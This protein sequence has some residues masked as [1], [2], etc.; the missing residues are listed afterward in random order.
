[1]SE[2]VTGEAVALELRLAKLPSR[3]LAAFIDLMLQLMLLYLVEILGLVVL[4]GADEGLA[5]ALII[6]MIVAIFVGYPVTMETL[7]RGRT[8]GK[9]VMGIRVVREDGGPIGF[10]QALVRGLFAG[11]LEKPGLLFAGLTAVI[12]IL[13]MLISTK[14]KRVG[15]LAAGTVVLQERVPATKIAYYAQMPPPLAGWAATLDITGVDDSLAL[16]V[17]QFLS[18]LAQLDDSARAELGER[19]S[20]AVAAVTTPPPPPGTPG[21]A[22][23]SAVLAE[24]RRREEQRL[25]ARRPRYGQPPQYGPPQYGTPRAARPVPVPAPPPGPFTPPG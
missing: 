17:R 15:D 9:M 23:L 21:W 10:R 4:A 12:G 16:S 11:L 19:L 13:T 3:L 20:T 22:Y 7:T 2:I 14:G 24:R 5:V 25:A 18:R 1:M 8:L 6:L